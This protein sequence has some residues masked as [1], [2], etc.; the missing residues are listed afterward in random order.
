MTMIRIKITENEEN[1]RLDRFLKKYLRN[2][3]LSYIYKL[4]RKGV[5]INGKRVSPQTQ[6][7][8][9]DEIT[10]FLNEEEINSY[11]R[12]EKNFSAKVQ[13]HI[14]YEDN[15]VLIVDKPFGLL[16]HGTEQE[17]KKTLTNQVITYLIEQG[18]YQP[19]R[20]N[21][22]VPAPVNRLDR[23]TTGLVIFGKNY[24][25]LKSLNQM[26]RERGFIRKYYLTV[27]KGELKKELHLV[28]RMKKDE[29]S[30]KIM[31][32]SRDTDKGKVMETVARPLRSVG[33]YTLVEVE[34]ITGRTHQIRAHLAKAG[35]PVIGDEKYGDHQVNQRMKRHFSLTTQ[36]LHAHRLF[37]SR[38]MAPLENM[39]GKE[40][41]CSLPSNLEHICKVLF[42]GESINGTKQR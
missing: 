33:G 37:F 20:E 35:Y 27:V 5:K 17:K 16:V 28:D 4:I 32:L 40:I 2:A 1:Q 13:F 29:S 42:E 21:V 8:L 18:T 7:T 41:K 24:E 38:G 15:N 3:P 36:F 9:G 12:N 11:L 34:I 19:S 14:A 10:L 26:L 22:F 31:V 23:N 30:N 6:L 25:S 39:I